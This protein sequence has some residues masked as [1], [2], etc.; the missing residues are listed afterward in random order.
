MMA[1]GSAQTS[2]FRTATG[3]GRI[4]HLDVRDVAAAAAEIAG[5]PAGHAGKRYWPTGPE[6]L[7]GYD[8]AEIFAKVLGR[9]IT[10]HPISYE[11]QKQAMIDVGLPEPVARD[12]AL[13]VAWM[14]DGDCDYVTGDVP[15]IL[16]RPADS[17][18]Q[19]AIDYAEAFS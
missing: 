4:G 11:V 16:G 5:S 12:N 15:Q 19:F 14:A 13:A 1:A 6:S 9:L 18:E 10:F 2:S 8:V 7:S 17:F 3:D